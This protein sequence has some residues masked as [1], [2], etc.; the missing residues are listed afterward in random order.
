MIMHGPSVSLVPLDRRHLEATRRWANDWEIAEL[1]DRATPVSDAAHEH[2]FATLHGK[3]D[4]VYFAIEIQAEDDTPSHVGNVW[5]WDI[6]PRHRKCEVRIVVGH[7]SVRSQGL[8]T[9]ALSLISKYAFERLNLHKVFALVLASNAR[10]V[11]AFENAGF[12]Q[13]GL[14]KNDRW[15]GERYVD[16]TMLGLL[17][18]A[19]VNNVPSAHVRRQLH[20][21][22]S[23][24][25]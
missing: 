17:R 20:D 15:S 9:Q 18:E 16:V 14:L 6:D 3:T 11:R 4:R 12:Q 24:H 19:R 2:W 1:M 7:D 13:E 22:A 5:L 21:T 10:A 8:G 23:H 25:A